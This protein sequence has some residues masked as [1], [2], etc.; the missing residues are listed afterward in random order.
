MRSRKLTCS[1]WWF[2]FVRPSTLHFV[3]VLV[4]ANA[5]VRVC[6][7]VC[8]YMCMQALLLCLYT[9]LQNG[10]SQTTPTVSGACV[11]ARMCVQSTYLIRTLPFCSISRKTDCYLFVYRLTVNFDVRTE[12]NFGVLCLAASSCSETFAQFWDIDDTGA[13]NLIRK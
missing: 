8:V 2:G 13:Y 7:H 12:V 11:R 10:V 9:W 6:M 3:R 1:W 4:R 5:Y